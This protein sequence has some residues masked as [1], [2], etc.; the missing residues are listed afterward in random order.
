V[1]MLAGF[2]LSATVSWQVSVATVLAVELIMLYV[3]RDNLFLN[4]LMLLAPSKKIKD[5]Q[6]RQ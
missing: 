5:W 4:V 6:L 2:V 3:Y 1:W